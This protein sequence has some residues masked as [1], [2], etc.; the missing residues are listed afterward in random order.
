MKIV[1]LNVLC[2][3]QTEERFVHQVLKPYLM[4]KG[5]VVKTQLLVTS[6]KNKTSG[7]VLSYQQVINDLILWRRSAVDN[8]FEIHHFTTMIDFYALPNNFPNYANANLLNDPY[9]CVEALE[10]AFE[11]DVRMDRFIPYIQLHEFEALVFCGLEYLLND[12]PNMTAQVNRLKKV[13]VEYG[14][15][16]ELINN[17]VHTAPSKRIINELDSHHRYNKPKIG[18]YVTQEVGMDMLKEK[19]SHF[20]GWIERLE[21]LAILEIR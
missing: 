11:E 3:G 6:K 7:G 18:A 8:E 12:Y 20:R 2:E 1:I 9:G 19:C 21:N 17:S 14:D 15:N 13:L 4:D 5:L 16:P 10:M